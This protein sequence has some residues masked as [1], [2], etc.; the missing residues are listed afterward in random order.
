LGKKTF[1]G[2]QVLVAGSKNNCCDS[3]TPFIK[4]LI[5]SP[6]IVNLCGVFQAK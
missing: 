3:L 1:P 2:P 4:I 6:P 5:Y